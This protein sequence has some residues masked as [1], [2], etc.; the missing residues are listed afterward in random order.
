MHG[1]NQGRHVVHDLIKSQSPDIFLLQEHWLTPANLHNFA[2]QFP[3]YIGFGKSAMECCLESGPLK[4]RP[5]GGVI[6]LVKQNIANITEILNI[7]DRYVLVK[8]SDYVI[9][10]IYL[11]CVNTCDRLLIIDDILR[12]V[13]TIIE[14]M[15]NIT[16]IVGGDINMDLNK[17]SDVAATCLFRQFMSNCNLKR[18]DELCNKTKTFTHANDALGHYSCIDYFLVSDDSKLLNYAVIEPDLNLSD[19]LPIAAS[20]TF[21]APTASH[22]K[23]RNNT[24]SV[25]QLRWDQA[26]LQL[27]YDLT[28]LHLQDLLHEFTMALDSDD[29]TVD[30]EFL[31]DNT[32][33]RLVYIL[34][35][36]AHI[37]V[38]HKRKN[39]FK[40]WWSQEL[41]CLKETAIKSYQIWKAAGKPRSGVF[42]S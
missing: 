29:S 24:N 38:P 7:S 36:C 30:N 40:F 26:D 4:G 19:H 6:T 27:Y 13:E 2:I 3:D 23:A 37:T 42:F 32:Y 16:I 22:D 34:Q 1:F 10:N 25:V 35:E 15:S 9:L 5:F 28:G 11:P 39:F 20:F 17:S 18:C 14:N 21:I 41:D 31:I 33:N 8:M 12:E